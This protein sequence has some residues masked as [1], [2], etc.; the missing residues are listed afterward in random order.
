[1]RSQSLTCISA[2]Q[3]SEERV[4][5]N[6]FSHS[7]WD[8]Y[9]ALVAQ[10]DLSKICLAPAAMRY[11]TS[12]GNSTV[13]FTARHTDQYTLQITYCR[14]R[15]FTVSGT[16]KMYNVNGGEE[17]HLPLGQ[18]TSVQLFKVL[19]CCYGCLVAV[20][21]VRS[22]AYLRQHVLSIHF[23]C[24]LALLAKLLETL[25]RFM[26]LGHMSRFGVDNASFTMAT[27]VLEGISG[28]LF[29]AVLLLIS[30]GWTLMRDRLTNR[31]NKLAFGVFGSYVTVASAKLFCGKR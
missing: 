14:Q 3:D 7:Q 25:S 27:T 17:E 18:E 26:Q 2:V 16:F 1:M 13:H 22:C 9:Q 11:E 24:A 6:L 23:G 29:L 19:L 21:V 5:F 10:K 31:E 30:L 20:F 15:E 28:I 8:S 12:G 4:L